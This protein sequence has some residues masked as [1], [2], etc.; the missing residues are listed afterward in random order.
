MSFSFLLFCQLL[1]FCS[2]RNKFV[3][4]RLDPSLEE[5]SFVIV[6]NKTWRC[7]CLKNE[8]LNAIIKTERG[9]EEMVS[10]SLSPYK[11]YPMYSVHRKK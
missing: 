11:S 4:S 8:I 5:F 7:T 3:P 9:K 6:A 1:S 2:S 10:T